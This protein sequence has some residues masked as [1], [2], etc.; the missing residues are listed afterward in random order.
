M[1]SL[2]YV[3]EAA[4]VAV[5]IK[6]CTLLF[7][8]TLHLGLRAIILCSPSVPSAEMAAMKSRSRSKLGMA[9]GTEVGSEHVLATW[10]EAIQQNLL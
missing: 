6:K 9:A 3:Y 8:C 2:S 1:Q 5:G 4:T 7:L 10:V